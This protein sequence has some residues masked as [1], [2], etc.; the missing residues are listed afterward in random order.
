[1]H[2]LDQLRHATWPERTFTTTPSLLETMGGR[3]D[4]WLGEVV[5]IMVVSIS[6]YLV[7]AQDL[8]NK[9]ITCCRGRFAP[10]TMEAADDIRRPVQ[11]ER[12]M[13]NP[14]DD[15]SLVITR[16]GGINELPCSMQLYQAIYNDI[17]GKTEKLT[18]TY[19]VY[20]E[21]SLNDLFQLENRLKQFCEQYLIEGLNA[22]ITIFFTRKDRRAKFSSFEQRD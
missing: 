6:A 13:M 4:V 22:S 20:Y 18:D 5:S 15:K 16:D 21:L 2:L 1:M 3:I 14:D 11:N 9:I 8:W 12:R 19:D 10:A 7:I 17:T